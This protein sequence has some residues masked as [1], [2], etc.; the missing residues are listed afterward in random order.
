MSRMAWSCGVGKESQAEKFFKV[1]LELN[2]SLDCNCQGL[3]AVVGAWVRPAVLPPM[4]LSLDASFW[5]PSAGWL[6]LA[7]S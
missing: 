5:C 7:L 6:Q 4:R 1:V 2:F 3:V